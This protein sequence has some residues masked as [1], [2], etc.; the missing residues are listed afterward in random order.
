MENVCHWGEQVG[1]KDSISLYLRASFATIL[2]TC[3]MLLPG[4]AF[5][6]FSSALSGASL[7]AAKAA[8]RKGLF[9]TICV[10]VNPVDVDGILIGSYGRLK[11]RNGCREQQNSVDAV[12]F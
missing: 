12:S 3:F 4:A 10:C 6:A 1:E 2:L 9:W 5:A 8:E 7:T 11:P